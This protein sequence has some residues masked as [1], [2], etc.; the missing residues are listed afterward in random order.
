MKTTKDASRSLLDF[1]RCPFCGGNLTIRGTDQNASEPEFGIL[2]CH[3]SQY[4][5]VAGI[6]I[7]KRGVI[8]GAG[9]QASDVIK[10]I[11]AGRN[12]NALLAMLLPPPPI[13]VVKAPASVEPLRAWQE[14]AEA[15]LTDPGHQI[16][17]CDLVNI[18]YRQTDLWEFTSVNYFLFRF[19][20]SRYHIALSLSRLI[21]EPR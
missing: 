2:T 1:L 12:R 3:C 13:T 19:S 18:Y 8:G 16:A 4:P 14:H 11:D 15:I 21:H 9:Q 17:V 5:I 7:I 20:H 10:L 6:P